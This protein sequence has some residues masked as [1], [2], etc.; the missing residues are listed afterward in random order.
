MWNDPRGMDGSRTGKICLVVANAIC[1]QLFEKR[2]LRHPPRVLPG[3]F[4]GL[5]T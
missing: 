1:I 5:A 4:P 3:V 2:I